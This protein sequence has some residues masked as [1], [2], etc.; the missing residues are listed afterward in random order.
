MNLWHSPCVCQQAFFKPV[1][2]KKNPSFSVQIKR[3]TQI[4]IFFWHEK[5]G[6]SHLSVPQAFC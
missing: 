4:S 1:A 5:M 2:R 3:S 6:T